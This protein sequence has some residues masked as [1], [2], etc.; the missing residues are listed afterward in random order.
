MDTPPSLRTGALSPLT[1]DDLDAMRV[2]LSQHEAGNV[3]RQHRKKSLPTDDDQYDDLHTEIL[4]SYLNV[5][6]SPLSDD[7]SS[8][9]VSS[10][11]MRDD[12]VDEDG[13]E[14]RRSLLTIATRDDPE[15][16][17]PVSA[18]SGID[19]DDSHIHRGTFGCYGLGMAIAM[20]QDPEQQSYIVGD[21]SHYQGMSYVPGQSL[22]SDKQQLNHDGDYI[23]GPDP[24]YTFPGVTDESPVTAVSSIAEHNKRYTLLDARLAPQVLV[25]P[26]RKSSL[27]V[28]GSSPRNLIGRP[29][30]QL[31]FHEG[32]SD[33]MGN[34]DP[35]LESMTSTPINPI[36]ETVLS[37][38]DS[39]HESVAKFKKH[40]PSLTS[41]PSFLDPSL[42]I[43]KHTNYSSE[44]ELDDPVAAGAHNVCNY[45][46]YANDYPKSPQHRKFNHIHYSDSSSTEDFEGGTVTPPLAMS[47]FMN[48]SPEEAPSPVRKWPRKTHK[49]L[50]NLFTRA[51]VQHTTGRAIESH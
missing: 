37:S 45:N 28:T 15:V 11:S 49:R 21:E 48:V 26:P 47:S 33:S 31:N 16:E 36:S 29:I 7:S 10:S 18:V 27:P 35:D 9:G 4:Q 8:H 14:D 39:L 19:V 50:R 44:F 42:P 3:A 13:E 5:D 38:I 41:T 32:N 6:I 34:I 22:Y 51:A 12:D 23:E 1:I 2:F 17:T 30:A 43:F 40:S 24:D 20:E 25:V 46:A